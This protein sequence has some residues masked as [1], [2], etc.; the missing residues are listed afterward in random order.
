[1]RYPDEL[2]MAS[3]RARYFEHNGFGK[4]GGYDEP[5]VSF[6]LGPVP[7]R[8]PNTRE[9]VRAVRYHDLHHI[10]TGY[11]TTPIGEFEISAWEIAAGCRGFGAAWLLNLAGIA[12]GLLRAPRR[13]FRAFV[14]GR[15]SHTLYGEDY[16]SLLLE[17]V[18]NVR[19]RTGADTASSAQPTVLDLLLLSACALS[20]A[21]LGPALVLIGVPLALPVLALSG[22]R[23]LATALR[24]RTTRHASTNPTRPAAN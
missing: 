4:H 17:R 3:A 18:G 15:H 19:A 11:D 12:G 8:I 10:V 2:D 7:V 21:L 20:G 1:M 16:E 5:W 9:R 23:S 14:R 24:S 6:A 22:L 13:T